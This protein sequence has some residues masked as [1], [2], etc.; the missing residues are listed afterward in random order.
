MTA[1]PRPHVYQAINQ[2]VRA[3]S[4]SGIPKR[5]TN[6]VVNT[7]TLAQLFARRSPHWRAFVS[8]A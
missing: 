4:K 3:F 7:N 6:A 8:I 1:A 2:I 5:H